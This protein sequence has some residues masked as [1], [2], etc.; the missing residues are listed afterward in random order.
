MS[1]S[2]HRMFQWGHR[3]FARSHIS[4]VCFS[5]HCVRMWLINSVLLQVVQV[6]LSSYPSIFR[7]YL[8]TIWVPWVVLYR[9]CWTIGLIMLRHVLCQIVAFGSI[10]FVILF[11]AVWVSLKFFLEVFHGSAFFLSR[12][13]LYAVAWVRE[14]SFAPWTSNSLGMSRFRGLGFCLF[15]PC[16]ASA[17]L[18]SLPW[19]PLCPFTHFR[20]VLADLYLI[21]CAAFLKSLAFFIPIHLLFSQ[22]SR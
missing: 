19:V 7:Q 4:C 10:S 9:N 20:V 6:S 11:T 15:A 21:R 18:P 14:K 22:V 1:I 8:L 17:S 2:G 3:F 16:F 5:L 12:I 13:P